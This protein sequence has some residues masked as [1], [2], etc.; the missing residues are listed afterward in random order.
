MKEYAQWEKYVY[1]KYEDLKLPAFKK[2]EPLT[3][4]GKEHKYLPNGIPVERYSVP[5]TLTKDKI[6]DIKLVLF[7]G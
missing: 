2:L 5:R 6:K 4:D 3:T 7:L 1:K